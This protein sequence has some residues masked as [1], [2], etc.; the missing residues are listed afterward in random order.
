MEQ[1]G[2]DRDMEK[3]NKRVLAMLPSKTLVT[4]D[5]LLFLLQKIL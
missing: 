4:T 2:T 5:L 1:Q 3:K